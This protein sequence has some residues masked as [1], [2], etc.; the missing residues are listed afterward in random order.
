MGS[1]LTARL[2]ISASKKESQDNSKKIPEPKV[3]RMRQGRDVAW[4]S[5]K[6]TGDR[7]LDFIG[8]VES[9]GNADR[10]LPIVQDSF[11]EIEGKPT[12]N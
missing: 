6:E 3:H 7:T 2:E 4:D 5:T 11:G 12:N 1:A 8:P 9:H 10:S